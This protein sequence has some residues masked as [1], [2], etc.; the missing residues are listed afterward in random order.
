MATDESITTNIKHMQTKSQIC[1]VCIY[2]FDLPS[3]LSTSV[4]STWEIVLELGIF[5]HNA[6]S[7]RRCKGNFKERRTQEDADF[8]GSPRRQI[9]AS[10]TLKM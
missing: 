2:Q 10:V 6:F 4:L 8:L 3:T 9:V 7:R 1:C 5:H